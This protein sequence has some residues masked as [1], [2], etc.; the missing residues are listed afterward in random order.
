[1]LIDALY[2]M[3]QCFSTFFLITY[4]IIFYTVWE[5]QKNVHHQQNRVLNGKK[6]RKS[7]SPMFSFVF[8]EVD[9]VV[10]TMV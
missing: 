6:I 1:M 2:T 7:H 9:R 10:L 4:F 8:M 5:F 3:E